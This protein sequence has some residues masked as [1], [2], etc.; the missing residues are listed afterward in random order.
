MF[1]E[2][3]FVGQDLFRRE[4]F[5]LHPGDET[6][7]RI[8][9]SVFLEVLIIGID[10]RFLVLDER[11][12]EKPIPENFGRPFVFRIPFSLGEDEAYYV[13]G[14]GFVEFFPLAGADNDLRGG[15]DAAEIF[16]FVGII[17]YS[18]ESSHRRH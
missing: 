4:V 12:V 14:I 9:F 5:E 13:Q 16:N 8:S 2:S 15:Q 1:G 3:H 7:A 18:F 17:S 10:A 6:L 11:V